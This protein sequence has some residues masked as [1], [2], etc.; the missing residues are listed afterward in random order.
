MAAL[1]CFKTY[2]IYQNQKGKGFYKADSKFIKWFMFYQ[3][4]KK[5]V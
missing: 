1:N 4:K 2:M 5:R 3:M